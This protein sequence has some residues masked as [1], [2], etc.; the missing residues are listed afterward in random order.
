MQREGVAGLALMATLG[1]CM[2]PPGESPADPIR[3][4]VLAPLTG[5]LA[6]V[7]VPLADAAL[8][9]EQEVAAV[10]GLL[11]GRPVEFVIA[12]TQTDEAKA[13]TAARRLIQEEGVVAI[14]GAAAS[15]STLAAPPPRSCRPPRA[16][17][18]DFSFEPSPRTCFK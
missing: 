2:A 15:S 5:G 10:G 4:G 1:G 13:A 6:A 12:D 3:V 8:L 17:M 14:L 9:A 16:S 7:G 11:G 18:T